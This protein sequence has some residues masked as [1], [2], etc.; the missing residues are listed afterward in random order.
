MKA[1][2]NFFIIG[3]PKAG[4][5]SLW[6]GLR[7]HPD[8]FMPE[9]KEPKFFTRRIDAEGWGGY[10]SLF[11]KGKDKKARGEATADYSQVWAHPEVP[12]RIS[13][14]VPEA[15]LI[16]I[17]RHP[18]RR[19]ESAWKKE[20]MLGRL[21]DDTFRDAVRNYRPIVEDTRYF[22]NLDAYRDH[23]PDDQIQVVFLED[24]AA[25]PLR[26]LK[27]CDEFLGVDPSARSADDRGSR[28]N[29][30]SGNRTKGPL[31]DKLGGTQG[32]RVLKHVLPLPVRNF[33]RK[34]VLMKPLPTPEWDSQ[35]R[36]WVIEQTQDDVAKILAYAGKPPD[37]WNVTKGE[38]RTR[39][40]S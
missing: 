29:A 36:Q 1:T 24:L 25:H 8:V 39:S 13:H 14:H 27:A 16:Y 12:E 30:S 40:S 3:A 11:E 7:K 35:T 32:W 5:T 31:L 2:P 20:V 4:S 37:Y 28:K 33:V 38:E 19:V 34:N 21:P 18:L 15:R 23:F 22:R 17:V 10:H 26:V 9:P 6:D